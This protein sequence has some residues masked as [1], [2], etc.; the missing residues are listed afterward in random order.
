VK[1]AIHIAVD[2]LR[3]EQHRLPRDR[4]VVVYCRSG[5]RGHLALRTLLGLG[6]RDVANVTGGHVS[7]VAEGGFDLEEG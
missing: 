1:T 5:F 2:S 4:R 6:F 7:I 3:F